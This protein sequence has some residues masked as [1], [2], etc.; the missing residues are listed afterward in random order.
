LKRPD[1]DRLRVLFDTALQSSALDANRKYKAP[2]L[3]LPKEEKRG[4]E[5][6]AADPSDRPT[7]P[8]L[9]GPGGGFGGAG[10]VPA[11]PANRADDALKSG[12]SLT[13]DGKSGAKKLEQQQERLQELGKDLAEDKAPAKR[14]FAD[15]REKAELVRQLYRQ[16]EPTKEW[17]ENNYYHLLIT[18][19]IG[20]L[21]PPSSFWLDYARHDGNGPFLSKNLADASRNFTEMVL[22]L[23][24]LDLPFESGQ[25]DVKFADGA[26][27]LNPKTAAIAFHEIIRPADAPPAN[28]TVL[29]SQNFY[30]HGDRFREEAGE[31]ID[32]FVTDEFVIQ[33]VYG[34][35][36]VVTNP[37]SSR[38]RLTV[39]VQLPIGAIPVANGQYTKAVP[40]DLEPY[41]TQT[42]DY[43]FYFPKPGQFAQFPVHVAKEEK[44][45]AAV[46]PVTFNV[47]PKPTKLDT[48]SWAYVS[49]NGTDEEVIA[50]LNRENVFALN[51]EKI[52]F[53]MKDRG[54]FEAVTKLL[55]ER[56]IY[57]PTLWS[58]SILH[59][60]VPEARQ[61]LMHAEQIVAEAGGPIASP[62]LAIDPVARHQYEHLEYKPLVNARA[63]SLG[64]RRQIVNPRLHE[65]YHRFLKLLSYRRDLTDDDLLATTYYLLLQDRIEEALDFFARANPDRVATRM[66][67]D[68]CAAYLDL[69]SD[70]PQRARAIA[71]RYTG[72]PVDRWRNAFTALFKILDE[73][74]GRGA[75][76]VDVNDRGQ[77]Q[78]QL[79]ATEPAVEFTIEGPKVNLTWQ[80][81]DAVQLNYYLMD[82]ELL[83]SRSPFAQQ[84]GDQFASIKPNVMKEVKL[85][86][87]ANRSS[88][89]L[90]DELVD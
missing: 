87:G 37:T 11:P 32:K 51:L 38:Q 53:R 39:L 74:E 83:F 33:T 1:T 18:A 75:F 57:Q 70:D 31:K 52:A 88:V 79:A 47:V 61:F 78:G 12:E 55:R 77:R 21:V 68:Y 82:V 80:N 34:G 45:V 59:A 50:F 27:T 90:P 48:S 5:T 85:P 8:A 89:P 22:A 76:V 3:N 63:H 16:V 46:K 86:A 36:L 65:Q 64:E 66:Q 26:M 17:A 56:H 4:G 6:A 13:R 24:V 14:F 43:L 60:A 29:V 67:Y 7:S 69:Y 42:V 41:R 10:G 23:A 44:V 73:A 58:Y 25:H 35:H 19:Q 72:H 30:R 71:M 20:E 2:E 40:L 28:P 49:Q 62:L 84:F 9:P 54:F 15:E 81:L